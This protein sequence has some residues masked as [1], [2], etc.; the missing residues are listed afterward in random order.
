MDF[1]TNSDS[2]F[3]R[4]ELHGIAVGIATVFTYNSII[5]HPYQ[6]YKLSLNKKFAFHVIVLYCFTGFT[7]YL[8]LSALG[9]INFVY[10][11]DFVFKIRNTIFGSTYSINL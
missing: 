6:I 11:Y 5:I 3:I 2:F 1:R 8:F 4:Y 10:L 7:V 9:C